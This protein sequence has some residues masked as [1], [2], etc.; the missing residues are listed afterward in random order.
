MSPRAADSTSEAPS[1]AKGMTREE[2]KNVKVTEALAASERSSSPLHILP[3]AKPHSAANPTTFACGRSFL[4][5]ARNPPSYERKAPRQ[6]ASREDR[7]CAPWRRRRPWPPASREQDPLPYR[8]GRK[9][10]SRPIIPFFSIEVK[11][12][13]VPKITDAVYILQIR[14]I[15]L[16]VYHIIP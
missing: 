9:I 8:A 14:S 1:N 4:S 5:R 13:F 10:A 15:N 2:E 16:H 6:K 7:K 3:L 12:S 11:E